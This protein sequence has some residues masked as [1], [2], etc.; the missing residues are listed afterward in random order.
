[1]SEQ[2]LNESSINPSP[3]E[4]DVVTAWIVHRERAH[5]A[6]YLVS[7]HRATAEL[8][9]KFADA[10]P[11]EVSVLLFD[12]ETA[13][14]AGNL[15]K[16]AERDVD[17]KD[18]A[19]LQL[20][21]NQGHDMKPCSSEWCPTILHIL[22]ERQRACRAYWD[23]KVKKFT[24]ISSSSRAVLFRQKQ[25][26]FFSAGPGYSLK[27]W[28]GEVKMRGGKTLTCRHLSE[29]ARDQRKAFLNNVSRGDF[30]RMN[31]DLLEAA[32]EKNLVGRG[33]R[34]VH[35]SPQQFGELLARVTSSMPANSVRSCSIFFTVVAYCNA[36]EMMVFIEKGNPED[37]MGLKVKHYE[38]NIT[39]NMTH[40]RVLPEHL[41][42]LSILDFNLVFADGKLP[43]WGMDVGDEWLAERFAGQLTSNDK[44][45]QASSLF[46]ALA[47][48]NL[49][50]LD[51]AIL[52]LENLDAFDEVVLRYREL[53][54]ALHWALQDGHAGAI[55]R[56]G[57]RTPVMGRLG[58]RAAKELALAHN[59][60]NDPG[61]FG[62]LKYGH[63]AAVD[64]FATLL[65]KIV[66]L[67]DQTTVERMLICPR[68]GSTGLSKTLIA[69]HE[70][71]LVSMKALLRVV[72]DKVSEGGMYTFMLAT[73]AEG[74]SGLYAAM[75]AGHVR[76]IEVF[77]DLLR[78]QSEKLRPNAL[79]EILLAK[80]G[81]ERRSVQRPGLHAA[82]ICPNEG[83]IK[84][85]GRGLL[86]FQSSLSAGAL[87]CLVSPVDDPRALWALRGDPQQA[88]AIAAF[89]A[90]VID[91]QSGHARLVPRAARAFWRQF[92]RCRTQ[93]VKFFPCIRT[94]S[95]GYKAASIACPDLDDLFRRLKRAL[96]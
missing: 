28:N 63:S 75:Q 68:G 86:A 70:H 61:L 91:M 84:A 9:L 62:A 41:R 55:S 21:L 30:S 42:K 77:M 44:E 24:A 72:Q 16:G 47:T 54:L 94:I 29:A 85:Y 74:E 73:T 23:R 51:A 14:A 25:K 53:A 78:D 37:P 17:S 46:N 31:R 38:P 48:G 50:E 13:S 39:G 57:E 6:R 12:E 69:G 96:R 22:E 3:S 95:T 4:I 10:Y 1:M 11:D 7:D 89:I 52:K 49:R 80:G 18:L 27:N 36:H 92:R 45:T 35:F 60:T 19:L 43:V 65:K 88:K 82:L 2:S 93:P 20:L 59:L 5:L 79:E 8:C 83:V 64:A 87:S 34:S 33:R 76:T 90:L 67:L 56:I 26:P 32:H 66:H 81:Y 71:V 40:L 58:P 15:L